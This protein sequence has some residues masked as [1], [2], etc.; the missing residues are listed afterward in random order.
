MC[1]ALANPIMP[2]KFIVASGVGAG[3]EGFFRSCKKELHRSSYLI[4]CATRMKRAWEDDF[5]LT[6][7]CPVVD[8]LPH[9]AVTGTS[10]STSGVRICRSWLPPTENSDAR[11]DEDEFAVLSPAVLIPSLASIVLC[12]KRSLLRDAIE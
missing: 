10:Y 12:Q 2:K 7:G 1:T 11:A 6:T 3:R 8:V 5:P 4:I 9:N